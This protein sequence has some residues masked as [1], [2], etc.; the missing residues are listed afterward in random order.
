[1]S[2]IRAQRNA[3]DGGVEVERGLV[4]NAP[5]VI[6]KNAEIEE[7]LED[8][9][10]GRIRRRVGVVVHLGAGGAVLLVEVQPAAERDVEF[11]PQRFRGADLQAGDD[12]G[13]DQAARCC[14]NQNNAPRAGRGSLRD[15]A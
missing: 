15:D 1:M 6:A 8:V 14:S 9:A 3:H 10:Y 4:R 12:V 2:K 11:L 5:L 13:L 7:F